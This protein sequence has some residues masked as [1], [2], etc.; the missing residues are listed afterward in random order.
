[1]RLAFLINAHQN[2]NQK[3]I[4]SA[5]A[6]Q[7][8]CTLPTQPIYQTLLFDF[9]R[10]WFRDYHTLTNSP[11]HAHH[12]PMHSPITYTHT[13]LSSIVIVQSHRMRL[14][15][16]GGHFVGEVGHRVEWQAVWCELRK[17]PFKKTNE[18]ANWS[19]YTSA[20]SELQLHP[21]LLKHVHSLSG[22]HLKC[23]KR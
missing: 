17:E 14:V 15:I 9:S 5:P 8:Q 4:G 18:K 13:N 6:Y 19:S 22:I 11:S 3:P 23:A 20:Y 10:V 16:D 21:I 7:A 1:M 2:V 12:S